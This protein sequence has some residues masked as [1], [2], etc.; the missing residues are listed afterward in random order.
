M[1]NI[2][3]NCIITSKYS[4]ATGVIN[5]TTGVINNALEIADTVTDLQ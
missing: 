4:F 1:F 3:I 5:K 2:Y